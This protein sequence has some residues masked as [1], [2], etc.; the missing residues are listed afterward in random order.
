[1]SWNTIALSVLAAFIISGPLPY[2]GKTF[3]KTALDLAVPSAHA[4]PG[5]GKANGKGKG[6]GN[7]FGRCK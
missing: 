3:L 4:K 2:F 7:A 5:N 6:N 1:M